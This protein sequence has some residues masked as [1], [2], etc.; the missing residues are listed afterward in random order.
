MHARRGG[1]AAESIAE[2]EEILSALEAGDSARAAG[3]VETHRMRAMA[4]LAT[5]N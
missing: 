3:A 4:R 1:F 5:T 2:H